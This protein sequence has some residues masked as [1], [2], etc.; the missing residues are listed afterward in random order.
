LQTIPESVR[1]FVAK[2][3]HSIDVLEILLLL[4]QD[5]RKEWG[6]FAVSQALRLDRTSVHTRLHKLFTAGLVSRE[7]IASEE[8]FHYH[9]ANLDLRRGVDELVKWYSSHRVALISVI[10]SAAGD[11]TFI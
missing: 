5:P 11:Q 9:P 7:Y 3:V 4:R 8:V 10:Y 2:Y 6:A 1:K